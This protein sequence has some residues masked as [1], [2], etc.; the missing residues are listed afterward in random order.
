MHP[1]RISIN[2]IWVLKKFEKTATD[3]SGWDKLKKITKIIKPILK[4]NNFE[5]NL[6]KI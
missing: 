5:Y 4:K 1:K 2:H 3:F 6:I